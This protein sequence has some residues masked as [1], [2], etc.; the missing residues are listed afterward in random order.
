VN[1]EL[2]PEV[3]HMPRTAEGLA[4]SDLLDRAGIW[5]LAGLAGGPIGLDMREALAGLPAGLDRERAKRLLIVAERPFL[6]A[7]R[8]QNEEKGDGQ[9]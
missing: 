9:S 5:K 1:G 4:I 3:E 2:C 8:E 6:V 7:W